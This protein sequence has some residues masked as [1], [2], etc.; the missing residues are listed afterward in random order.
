MPYA[1]DF[2]SG[3]ILAVDAPPPVVDCVKEFF[4]E[5]GRSAELSG[6]N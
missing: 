5:R 3:Q 1:P 4:A 6:Q 2:C